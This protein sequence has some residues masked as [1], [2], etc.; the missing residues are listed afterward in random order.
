M[1]YTVV[2]SKK[3]NDPRPY[4]IKK[5]DTG[6]IVGSSRT[7]AKAWSS[8]RHREEGSGESVKSSKKGKNHR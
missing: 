7:R 6:E 8:I 1:P 4:K 5:R 2:K 3:K